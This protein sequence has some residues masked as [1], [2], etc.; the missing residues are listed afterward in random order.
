[1]NTFQMESWIAFKFLKS[2]I[3]GPNYCFSKLIIIENL[4]PKQNQWGS[5]NIK[6][7]YLFR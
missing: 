3:I 5:E 1:M 6:W 4:E 2:A 7:P